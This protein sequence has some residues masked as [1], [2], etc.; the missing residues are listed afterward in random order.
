MC[1]EK[2]L[3]RDVEVRQEGG[4]GIQCFYFLETG[5]LEFIQ[6]S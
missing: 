1:K 3:G 2:T 4:R 6:K 5:L